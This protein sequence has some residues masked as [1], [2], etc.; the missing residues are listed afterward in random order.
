[1]PHHELLERV[2]LSVIPIVHELP[3]IQSLLKWVKHINEGKTQDHPMGW[4][5]LS[6]ENWSQEA[7]IEKLTRL[8][9][10]VN[11]LGK[12]LKPLMSNVKDYEETHKK[13]E[14]SIYTLHG[15]YREIPMIEPDIQLL[16]IGH[17]LYENPDLVDHLFNYADKTSTTL[18]KASHL[19]QVLFDEIME[20]LSFQAPIQEKRIQN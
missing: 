14:R 10:S 20:G 5:V 17:S 3:P 9:H 18:T 11:E 13:V 6:E 15:A 16:R 1:M 19:K 8:C 4:M 7:Q 12:S 2:Q